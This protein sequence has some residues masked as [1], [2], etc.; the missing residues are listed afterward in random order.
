MSLQI[1]VEQKQTYATGIEMLAQQNEHVLQNA[2]RNESEGGKSANF[3]Q[4]GP[5]RARQK[6]ERHGDTQYIST[7]HKRRWVFPSTFEFADLMDLADLVK[8]VEN[9][10]GEYTKNMI[11][12]INRDKDRDIIAAA[13]GTS[14]IGEN[15]TSTQTLVA[16]NSGSNV[17][18]A[19]GT[20]FTLAKL[21]D[22]MKFMKQGNGVAVNSGK[23]TDDVHVAWTAAQ[24]AEFIDTT[25]VK[26]IDYNTQRVLVS[27]GMDGQFY[28]FNFHRLEDWTDEDGNTNRIMP[29]ASTTRTCVAWVKSGLLHNTFSPIQTKQDQNM[30]KNY[31][32]Q[33]WIHAMYGSTRMQESKVVQIDVVEA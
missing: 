18:A 32:W 25:E 15:G 12:S 9:P 6:A 26:S 17:I 31:S 4:I 1:T 29:K 27:G 33:Y 10:G 20:G 28:G 8:I 3:Q 16:Y 30:N 11:A 7:P 23:V 5:V 22:A 14:Y 19:G 21:K 13:I 24:E 2:V